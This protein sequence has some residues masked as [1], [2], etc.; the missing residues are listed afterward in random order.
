MV[1]AKNDVKAREMMAIFQLTG[2]EEIPSNF[3][4]TVEAIIRAY[5]PPEADKSSKVST[6]P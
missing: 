1:N 4:Q 5:P 3:H 2:F 6:T